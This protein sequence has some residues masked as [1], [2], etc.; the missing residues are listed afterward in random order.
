MPRSKPKATRLLGQ[1]DPRPQPA[2]QT[3]SALRRAPP[4]SVFTVQ[5]FVRDNNVDQAL[6]VLKKKLQREGVLRE[7]RLKRHYEKPSERII[8]KKAE[9]VRRVRKLARKQAIREG[10]IAAPKKKTPA[11]KT[12]LPS[13]AS[14]SPN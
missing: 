11:K 13:L 8:R 7:L 9:A 1:A 10:L 4:I 6:R 3:A 12:S 2:L 14:P 5:V